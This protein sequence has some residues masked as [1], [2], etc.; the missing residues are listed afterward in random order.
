[1]RYNVPNKK[2]KKAKTI[3]IGTEMPR[4]VL[5]VHDTYAARQL[6]IPAKIQVPTPLERRDSRSSSADGV[7]PSVSDAKNRSIM[8]F[9]VF[10]E[11]NR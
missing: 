5:H 2:A 6:R 10:E 1:V 11:K 9:D 7:L 8:V 4:D 3:L